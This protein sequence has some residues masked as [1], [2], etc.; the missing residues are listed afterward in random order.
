MD[1]EFVIAAFG[2]RAEQVGR[3][4]KNIRFYSPLPIN[5]ITTAD[6]K[7]PYLYDEYENINRIY[8]EPIWSGPRAEIRNS[9][10]HKINFALEKRYKSF[11][12]LDD[13]MLIVNQ[14]YISGFGIAERFGAA[15]P[16]NPRVFNKYNMM[17]ADVRPQD[18]EQCRG[19]QLMLP[20]VNFSPFFVQAHVGSTGNFLYELKYQLETVPCRGTVAITKAMWITHYSPV[21]LPEQWCVCASNAAYIKSHTEQLRGGQ[22][23]I[24]TIMLHLGHDKVKEVYNVE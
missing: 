16:A 13:D 1:R 14:D 12:L 22:L 3:L 17:G 2:K 15:L 4:V 18:W 7:T 24:E 11:C 21:I 6:S 5:I 19:A 23:S 9:N 20:A 10:F 8:V